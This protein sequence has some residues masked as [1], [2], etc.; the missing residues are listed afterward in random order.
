MNYRKLSPVANRRP[1]RGKNF[2]GAGFLLPHPPV[3]VPEVGKGQEKA[4][5][6]TI[7]ALKKVAEKIRE[8][9]PDTVVLLSPHAPMFRD[10][11]FIYNSPVLEGDLRQFR[12]D[13]QLSFPQDTAL[14]TEIEGLM[15][16]AGLPG[17]RLDE[18][19]M[20]R[21][22]LENTL[23]HGAFVPLYY[24]SSRYNQFQL[25]AMAPS[26]LDLQ[27]LYQLGQIIR[28]AA[29][30]LHKRIV[31]VA[32]G[33]LSHRVNEE[34]PYGA[35][36]EGAA[37]DQ[38]LIEHLKQGDLSVLLTI[39]HHLR[40]EAAECGYRS[41]IVL[42]G[43]FEGLNPRTEVLS[44][45]APFGI[46][47]GVAQFLPQ[48][49]DQTADDPLAKI[50]NMLAKEREAG[51][52]PVQIAQKTLEEYVLNKQIIDLQQLKTSLHQT[53]INHNNG[54]QK[55]NETA[56]FDLWTEKAGVFVSLKKFGEL[57]GCI[58]TTEPTT[59]SIAEEIRQNAISA[60]TKD[61]RFTP[62]TPDELPFLE[63]SVDVLDSPIPVQSKAE[64]D[65][66]KYGVIVSQ[67]WR[68]GLLLPDLEGVDT[69]EEQLAIACQKAGIDP[70]DTYA[71]AKFTVTRFK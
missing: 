32:S 7:A 66:K 21:H 33:D 54:Q 42:C 56:S 41:L 24:L 47:Y 1:S 64:L 31:L 16:A 37:F 12:A 28:Q 44:Y 22:G 53:D 15:E 70:H 30:K 49:T 34:S 29:E 69:V 40:E 10:F 17:G 68:R 38:Q 63:Y 11:I 45:E 71:I 25:V 3:I 60:G 55:E 4:A 35:C 14:I 8:L 52:L 39:N 9:E 36:P 6:Q 13:C 48:P 67:G 46:G 23:D 65:P 26:A 5:A 62:V 19:T 20:R 18:A 2:L 57:R 43:A 61:P 59:S 27:R 51:S 50:R 58:G